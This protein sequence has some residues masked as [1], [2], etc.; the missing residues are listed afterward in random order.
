MAAANRLAA[1]RDKEAKEEMK[2]AKRLKQEARDRG[3]DVSS[4][5]DND[6]DDDDGDDEV[7]VDV[8]W[9]VLEDEETLTSGHPPVQGPFAFHAEGSESMR[10]VEAG[11]SASS[12]GVPAE[13]RWM[14]KGEPVAAIPEATMKGSSSGAAPRETMEGDG[15]GAAPDETMERS[16]SGAAPDEMDP[17]APEQGVGMKRSRPDEPGQGSGDPS[18]KRFR[19]PRT[20]T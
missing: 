3:E 7:A 14:G 2:K 11:E 16:D 17:P 19:R 4:E 1:E 10:S 15:S 6:D 18:P 20:S 5:D 8:D 9:G 12:H 13:D